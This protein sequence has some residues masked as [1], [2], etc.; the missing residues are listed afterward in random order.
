MNLAAIKAGV[1]I[2]GCKF[3]MVFPELKI[4]NT[5]NQRPGQNTSAI[6]FSILYAVP[7]CCQIS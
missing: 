7:Q 5:V 3:I 6:R 4:G 1:L 2:S